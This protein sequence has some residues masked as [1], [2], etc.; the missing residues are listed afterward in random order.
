LGLIPEVPD[1]FV[2]AH[3][4]FYPAGGKIVLPFTL[5]K[6][7]CIKRQSRPVSSADRSNLLSSDVPTIN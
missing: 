1:V 2:T 7:L 5:S 6:T 3:L 4:K